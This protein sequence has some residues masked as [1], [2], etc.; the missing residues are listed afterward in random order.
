MYKI[1]D[2]FINY[3]QSTV[4]KIL[5]IRELPIY[6]EY[7]IQCETILTAPTG[8]TLDQLENTIKCTPIARLLYV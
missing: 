3:Q 4:W 7:V 6:R 1:G 5:D 2:K 8:V